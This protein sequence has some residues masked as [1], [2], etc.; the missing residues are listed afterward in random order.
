MYYAITIY[1]VLACI[2]I[3]EV[4]MAPLREDFD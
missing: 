3:L 4:W 2:A 1:T